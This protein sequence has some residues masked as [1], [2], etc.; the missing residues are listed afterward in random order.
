VK[1]AQLGSLML[2]LSATAVAQK[3]IS[4]RP[5]SREHDDRRHANS[6]YWQRQNHCLL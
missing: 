2:L 6:L 4:F 1:I 3:F 5:K